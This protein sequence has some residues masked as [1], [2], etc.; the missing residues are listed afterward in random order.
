MPLSDT[1]PTAV[2]A[3]VIA[4]IKA[5]FQSNSFCRDYEVV[6][7]NKNISILK[8]DLSQA[9]TNLL[10]STLAL[11]RTNQDT[12]H[13]AIETTIGG[14][15]TAARINNMYLSL[16]GIIEFSPEYTLIL[17]AFD[18]VMKATDGH[19]D[20][21]VS[22]LLHE[23]RPLV[24]M[25]SSTNREHYVYPWI[26]SPDFHR[27]GGEA[28]LEAYILDA[29]KGSD[30]QTIILNAMIPLLYA[31]STAFRDLQVSDVQDADPYNANGKWRNNAQHNLYSSKPTATQPAAFIDLDDIAK[32]K[33]TAPINR[34]NMLIRRFT[35]YLIK[36]VVNQAATLNW[37]H[38]NSAS[39][40]RWETMPVPR[41]AANQARPHTLATVFSFAFSNNRKSHPS[42][43]F[44]IWQDYMIQS[45]YTANQQYN[46]S[47]NNKTSKINFTPVKTCSY[48]DICYQPQSNF[49]DLAKSNWTKG[50][51][52]SDKAK[53]LVPRDA[54]I[55]YSEAG[56]DKTATVELNKLKN[57][58]SPDTAEEFAA[59]TA[60]SASKVI[61]IDD[62]RAYCKIT[63][64]Y[65]AA[66]FD[67]TADFINN[68]DEHLVLV[69]KLGHPDAS[70]SQIDEIALNAEFWSFR[71][72]HDIGSLHPGQGILF[73]APATPNTIDLPGQLS[74]K[75]LYANSIPAL[76]Q[77]ELA[78]TATALSSSVC[79]IKQT[80]RYLTAFHEA[81]HRA[82][83][84]IEASDMYAH[85]A[86][87]PIQGY[88]QLLALSDADAARLIQ[89]PKERTT[90]RFYA[91]RHVTN[92]DNE[93]SLCSN[94]AA[95]NR[96]FRSLKI[97]KFS[98]ERK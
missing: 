31:F 79:P 13:D 66:D 94:V 71:K 34:K 42:K 32:S 60:T 75:P 85:T 37:R 73:P 81:P 48:L 19:L 18:C 89:S 70:K 1:T 5:R 29:Q 6:S 26:V 95:T 51:M 87:V 7:T 12:K 76:D 35:H 38:C 25:D 97:S 11:F 78:K 80:A 86:Y 92:A 44:V 98:E 8:I 91:A 52:F 3:T 43:Q 47:P 68:K 30:I 58:G 53:T 82:K 64:Q 28:S 24:C 56:T 59:S 40:T 96:I 62:I 63:C 49:P 65:S 27:F 69:S 57:H 83:S 10:K 46:A 72:F 36:P 50:D 33:T 4:D 39:S 15:V 84:F 2:D 21:M 20:P 23:L 90:T 45:A 14:I 54:I 55:T 77:I 93:D 74:I 17:Q 41:R 88:G 61:K 9:F 67:P 16:K 22:A